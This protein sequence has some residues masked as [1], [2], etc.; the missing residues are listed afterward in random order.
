L[1]FFKIFLFIFVFPRPLTMMQAPDSAMRAGMKRASDGEGY[2][3]FDPFARARA[4][5]PR[6]PVEV[7]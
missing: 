5:A 6:V 4:S 2:H 3:F 1:F 7:G